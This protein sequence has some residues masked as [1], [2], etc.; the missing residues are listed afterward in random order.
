[1]RPFTLMRTVVVICLFLSAAVITAGEA[2]A[3]PCSPLVSKV[4][5]PGRISGLAAVGDVLIIRE[6]GRLKG[7]NAVSLRPLWSSIQEDEWEIVDGPA[8]VEGKTLAVLKKKVVSGGSDSSVSYI[9]SLLLIDPSTGNVR[10]LSPQQ[11]PSAPLTPPPGTQNS[12]QLKGRIITIGEGNR[13]Q[14]RD[15][16]NGALEWDCDPGEPLDFI[17]GA[18]GSVVLATKSGHLIALGLS[19]PEW[20]VDRT[21]SET[22]S[23]VMQVEPD[24]AFIW[25]DGSFKGIA[26]SQAFALVPGT[27]RVRIYHPDRALNETLVDVEL[28]TTTV[29]RRELDALKEGVLTVTTSPPGAILYVNG[30]ERKDRRQ[31]NGALTLYDQETGQTID[32]TLKMVGFKPFRGPVL[33]PE[34]DTKIHKDLQLSDFFMSGF[35]NVGSLEG[36]SVLGWAES[37]IQE[38]D[39]IGEPVRT[40]DS[41]KFAR[42]VLSVE[43]QR[44]PVNLFYRFDLG[45]A[46]EDDPYVKHEVGTLVSL[47]P[48]LRQFNTAQIGVSYL[49]DSSDK[50]ESKPPSKGRESADPKAPLELWDHPVPNVLVKN[51]TVEAWMAH[52]RF[53]PR[54]GFFLQLAAGRPTQGRMRG[55]ALVRDDQG[56]LVRDP[57][58]AYDIRVRGGSLLDIR[59]QQ[60]IRTF[61]LWKL[62]PS[63]AFEVRYRYRELDFG[64]ARESGDELS[65]S[66]G[67]FGS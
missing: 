45:F 3:G 4:Q 35:L 44:L 22:G 53:R 7:L 57:L 38:G 66:L 18:E 62:S 24:D 16:A 46:E 12:L 51:D 10:D 63:A 32:F 52:L 21:I 15:S 20:P 8:I 56:H 26:S 25:I 9:E 34:G 30:V 17:S 36:R 5:R 60:T 29:L 6:D 39:V 1:M 27:H 33:I 23:L 19:H 31:E 49:W 13:V 67:V 64:V 37:A 47:L 2:A 55:T 61:L 48:S 50:A 41:R 65:F 40:G 54:P 43:T 11:P 59:Y 14:A 42:M 28:D 58:R